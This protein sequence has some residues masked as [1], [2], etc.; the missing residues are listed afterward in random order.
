MP[1]VIDQRI[2]SRLHQQQVE[3]LG[4]AERAAV[5]VGRV[6][7]RLL[8]DL[9]G[10]AADTPGVERAARGARD[11][12]EDAADRAMAT[13]RTELRSSLFASREA[14][15]ATLL[16]TVPVG[17]FRAVRPE[18]RVQPLPEDEL[19]PDSPVGAEY[20]LEP[21]AARLLSRE[22]AL[23]LIRELVFPSLSS[24]RV[25]E[26][27]AAGANGIS[28]DER[29]RYWDQQVRDQLLNHLVQGISAGE[30]VDKLRA[31][32][33]PLVGDI[34]YKAQ[35][36]AR[37]EACRVAE[38]AQQAAFDDCGE[39]IDGM[40]IVATLDQWTR[41]HH[42]TRNGK[43]YRRQPDGTYQADDGQP[44][45]ELPDEPNCRCYASA[46]LK[47]PEE[48]L[49]DPAVRAEFTNASAD[50]IP[51]PAAY[52]EWFAR[53]SDQQRKLAVGVRRYNAM[54]RRLGGA[55]RPEWT[56]FIDENGRLLSPSRLRSESETE[57]AAR[58]LTVEQVLAQ[59]EELFREVSRM[60]FAPE[61]QGR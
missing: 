34:R 45:P 14:A 38:R 40:Q 2:A 7:D 32:L 47:P 55:G 30:G 59:R 42:A 11:A 50:V 58:K 6:Y 33:E 12:I 8:R 31:R 52:T 41:P 37:T 60:G 23:A 36:I 24:E 39:L 49:G 9:L 56:D 17:W 54:A 16:R 61:L 48:F 53:A 5:N 18:L 22:E 44:L 19:P 46:V 1:S 10:V 25:A 43:I 27:L 57:R 51:D 21:V 20:E 28:W 3:R 29:L 13:M 35:R 26:F 15:V 4:N